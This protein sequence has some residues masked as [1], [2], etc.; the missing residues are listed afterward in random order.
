MH[1]SL[2]DGWGHQLGLHALGD[3]DGGRAVLPGWARHL[4]GAAGGLGGAAL[5]PGAVSTGLTL[6]AEEPAG[7][8]HNIG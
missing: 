8:H 1:L 7:N 2:W 6:L 3:P 5:A 4:Q